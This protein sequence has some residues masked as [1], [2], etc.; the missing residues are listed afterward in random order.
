M[1][2]LL[3]LV[4]VIVLETV[5]CVLVR[6]WKWWSRLTE[7]WQ[8]LSYSYPRSHPG[9]GRGR[10][11]W[12]STSGGSHNLWRLLLLLRDQQVGLLSAIELARGR[13]LF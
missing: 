5:G 12:W 13:G 2:R 6:L 11:C 1:L 9:D 10:G 7:W 4:I 3:L 8:R